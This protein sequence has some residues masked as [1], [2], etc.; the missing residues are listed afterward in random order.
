MAE[1]RTAPLFTMALQVSGMQPIGAT[2]NG[3]RRIGLVAGGT[4]EGAR[5]K[6]KVLP[7]GA[8]W[9]I[10]RSDGSTTLDVRLVLET[11][12]G[13]AIGMT[14]R[15]MR[16]GP[17]AVMDRVN[18]GEP[19]DPSEYYFRISVAFE[20]AAAKY[21]WLNRIIAVGTGRR[22]PEGPVYDLFE[23]L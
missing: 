4:F 5:L 1:L 15:G 22:P 3:N 14:Y 6:G 21:D 7:G 23:V 11:D 10:A 12:D 9:I 8:D 19:V 2:P 20:T 17:P 16:H 18:R 13:A